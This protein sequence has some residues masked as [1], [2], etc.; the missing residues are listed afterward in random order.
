MRLSR[1][2][3]FKTVIGGLFFSRL[4]GGRWEHSEK[5]FW[6]GNTFIQDNIRILKDGIEARINGKWRCFQRVELSDAFMEWN[7]KR[8]IETLDRIKE[9][10]RP[11]LAGPHSAAIATY[12]T[13]RLDSQFTINNAVKGLGFLPRKEILVDTIKEMER[14]ISDPMKQKLDFLKKIYQNRKNLDRTKQVSLELYTT[15]DFETHTFLNLMENP[16]ASIVFL[17]FPSYEIRALVQVLH[18]ENKKLTQYERNILRYVNLS[19]SYFHGRFE[20]E[21]IGL[22]FHVIELFDNTPGRMRGVRVV[23]PREE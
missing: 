19:H 7:L 5:S 12:G 4:F 8:R 18:P 15:K 17:D 2:G 6:K 14:T 22:V 1:R 21:F 10:K 23:P 3:F 20:R 9:G 16:V 13:R 11:D